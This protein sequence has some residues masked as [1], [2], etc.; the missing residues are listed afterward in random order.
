MSLGEGIRDIS[1]RDLTDEE[2]KE[3][4]LEKLREGDPLMLKAQEKVNAERLTEAVLSE[5]KKITQSGVRTQIPTFLRTQVGK[6]VYL[7]N[8]LIRGISPFVSPD[9]I[10]MQQYR[11]IYQVYWKLK[12][13]HL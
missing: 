13:R 6:G 7:A 11:R 10:A 4:V 12:N 8:E 3:F 5:A 2:K 9:E 1:P